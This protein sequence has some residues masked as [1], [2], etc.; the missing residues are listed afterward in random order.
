MCDEG[1]QSSLAA[2]ALQQLGFARATDVQGGSSRGAPRA[3]RWSNPA[4]PGWAGPYRLS[5]GGIYWAG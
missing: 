4:P 5:D 2:A 1:Y 3:F